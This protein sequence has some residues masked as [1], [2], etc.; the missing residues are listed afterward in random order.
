MKKS[1]IEKL[2]PFPVEKSKDKKRFV[3]AVAVEE[4]RGEEHLIVDIYRNLK[5]EFKEPLVRICLTD[6]DYGNYFPAEQRWNRNKMDNVQVRDTYFIQMQTVSIKPEDK[7]LIWTFTSIYGYQNDTWIDRIQHH[8][9][10]IDRERNKKYSEARYER[11][12]RELNERIANMPA[13][14]EEFYE[15]CE[16]NLL[17]GCKYIFYKRKGRFAEFHCGCCGA[18]Y[19]YAT[20]PLDTFEGQ[21]EHIVMVPKSGARGRCEKC[22]EKAIYKPIGRGDEIKDKRRCYMV[23]PYGDIGGAVVRYFEIYKTSR[24]GSIPCF[25]DVEINRSFFIPGKDKIQKDYQV[26]SN[27]TGTQFWISGNTPGLGS[28][29]IKAGRLYEGN[30]GELAGT[31]LKHSGIEEFAKEYDDFAVEGYMEAYRRMPALEMIVKMKLTYLADR[32]AAND[33]ATWNSVNVQGKSAADVLM[34][35]KKKI[36]KLVKEKGLQYYHELFRMEKTLGIDLPEEIED[37]LE[38]LGISISNLEQMLRYMSA[39]QV[40]NRIMRYC[41]MTELEDGLC[42][43]AV[44]HIRS[45]A[46]IYADYI[47]MRES[48]GYDLSNLIIQY[49]RNLL[50][51]HDKMVVESNAKEAECRIRMVNNKYKAIEERFEELCEKYQYEDEAFAIRPAK[52]AGEIVEEGRTLHHCVGGDGYL[53]NHARGIS[54]I[55]LLRLSAEKRVP[56]VTVEMKNLTIVQWYGAYNKKPIKN[57]IEKW[58][59][60]YLKILKNGTLRSRETERIM[61]IA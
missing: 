20:E 24:A 56:F 10:C 49:P 48:L 31:E 18:T 5:K 54:I 34:I 50:E 39:K 3:A 57:E 12:E 6:K 32:L 7:K 51:E 19:R 11:K 42:S 61:E 29:T 16:S 27:F 44:E 28:I 1:A 40:I 55:L 21:F 30:L 4:I 38:M 23:Q 13:I 53:G 9:D 26:Y 45:I 22:D 36:R 41:G 25:Q 47:S 8:E 59:K 2:K 58:L 35:D 43:R 60:N 37:K 14:P 15:W 52:N 33:Y 17:K 46:Q